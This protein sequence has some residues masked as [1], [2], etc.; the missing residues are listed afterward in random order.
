VLYGGSSDAELRKRYVNYYGTEADS[1]MSHEDLVSAVASAAA[2]EMGL[3][4]QVT[5]LSTLL[6]GE[7]GEVY[8]KILSAAVGGADIE[9]IDLSNVNFDGDFSLDDILGIK[10]FSE[11]IEAL[12]KA[13]GLETGTLQK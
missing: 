10:G 3:G 12:E 6:T 4:S 2:L 1:E 8:K 7:N 5:N 11:S 9:N 13:M